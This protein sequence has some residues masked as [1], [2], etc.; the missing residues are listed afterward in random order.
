MDGIHAPLPQPVGIPPSV[1]MDLYEPGR[2]QWLLDMEKRKRLA[3]DQLLHL[4]IPLVPRI[5][6][7]AL[8]I[9]G[10]KQSSVLRLRHENDKVVIFNYAL[11]NAPIRLTIY[12][13]I[14]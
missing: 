11:I 10:K 4:A 7:M 12:I 9:S 2:K 13:I 14:M 3:L 6:R 1:G 8:P 5:R